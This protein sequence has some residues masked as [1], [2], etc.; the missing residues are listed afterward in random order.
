MLIDG[1]DAVT[2][3]LVKFVGGFG[4][5]SAFLVLTKSFAFSNS[6]LGR[7]TRD[8]GQALSVCSSFLKD[9]IRS[10]FSFM[11]RSIFR[12]RTVNAA[13]FVENSTS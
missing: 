12:S 2:A 5:T 13:I 11:C 10:A 6:L 8:L 7:A 3:F 9:L 1:I 4:M